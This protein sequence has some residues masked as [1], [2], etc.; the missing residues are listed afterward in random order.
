MTVFQQSPRAHLRLECRCVKS[1]LD[2]L[3]PSLKD[4]NRPARAL[5]PAQR[6][7]NP[8]LSSKWDAS[9]LDKCKGVLQL[10]FSDLQLR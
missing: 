3:V 8:L 6:D 1:L 4:I 7:N 9:S 5:A 2:N 10:P